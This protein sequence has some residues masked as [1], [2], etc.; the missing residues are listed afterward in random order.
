MFIRLHS[1]TGRCI[2][3]NMDLIVFYYVVPESN[4]TTLWDIIDN[5]YEVKETLEEIDKMVG[6]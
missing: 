3:F 2:R 5:Y 4:C 1:K 6:L